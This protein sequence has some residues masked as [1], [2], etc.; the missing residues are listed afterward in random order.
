VVHLKR[1]HEQVKQGF[2]AKGTAGG[3]ADSQHIQQVRREHFQMTSPFSHRSLHLLL[4]EA[5]DSIEGS[6]E[7]LIVI[8]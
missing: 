2:P 3:S 8:F 1:L 7:N 6:Q 4:V 5:A